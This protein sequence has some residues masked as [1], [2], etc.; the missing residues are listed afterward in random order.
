MRRLAVSALAAGLVTGSAGAHPVPEAPPSVRRALHAAWGYGR[1]YRVA[2][3]VAW[4]ESRYD[5]RAR[6]ATGD[7]G[8]MQLHQATWDPRRNP[9]A[10]AVVGDIDWR[11]IYEVAYNVRVAWRIWQAWRRSTGEGWGAWRA[12][13]RS[14]RGVR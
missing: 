8:L 6:S 5:P 7:H 13:W 10:R 4:H 14:C 3:C 12:Y 9:R 11:R 1:D 2:L